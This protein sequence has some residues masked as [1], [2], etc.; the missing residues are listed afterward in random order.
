VTP[1]LVIL[2][3]LL[4]DDLVFSDGSTRMTQAGGAV[5]YAGLAARLWNVPTGCVSVRGDDYPAE[6]IDRLRRQTID[7]AGVRTLGRPGVRTWLLYEGLVRHLVHRIGCPTHEDVS[8]TPADIPSAWRSASAFHLAPMPFGVQRTLLSS[9]SAE[10][11]AFVSVDPHRPITEDTLDDWRE[12]LSHADAFFPS[13]DEM[14]LEEARA[15]PHWALSRL[16]SGRLRF[17]ALKRGA[18]GGLLFDA[19]TGQFHAWRAHATAVVDQTGA[20]DAFAMGFV[21][22]HLDGLPVE[23]CL[24][25]AV[26]SASFAI[27]GWGSGALLEA[28]PALAERR[29]REFYGSEARA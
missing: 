29:V 23:A 6:M 12:M 17:V 7:L 25:R 10:P 19:R 14:R 4:V 16:V 13:E 27:E 26:V 24:Q 8:P 11:G 5:L 2:G 1:K 21:S 3:N 18:A 28:T 15:D 20:G 9:L 22:A